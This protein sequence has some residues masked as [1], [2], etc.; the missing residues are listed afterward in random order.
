MVNTELGVNTTMKLIQVSIWTDLEV[1][2]GLWVSCFPALQPLLR[3]IAR[4][5]GFNSSKKSTSALA[6]HAPSRRKI[7]GKNTWRSILESGGAGRESIGDHSSVK[8]M[9]FEEERVEMDE[10]VGGE[11]DLERGNVC[12]EST[13]SRLGGVIK[14]MEVD[15]IREV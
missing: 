7:S 13:F 9:G 8:G 1:H 4:Q 5:L 3:L 15:V 11:R 10:N 2:V 6:N 14:T 12:T